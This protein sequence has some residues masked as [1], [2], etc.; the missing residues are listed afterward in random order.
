MNANKRGLKNKTF[1]AEL[2]RE[3]VR[4][5]NTLFFVIPIRAAERNL[6]P[7]GCAA[8]VKFELL[9]KAGRGFP[10]ESSGEAFARFFRE[11]QEFRQGDPG[12]RVHEWRQCHV[13]GN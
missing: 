12:G 13:V 3:S 1:A 11:L 5:P 7:A 10:A 9:H 8:L 4:Q 2:R 6:L